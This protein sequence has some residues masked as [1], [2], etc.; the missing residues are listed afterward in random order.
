VLEVHA[1]TKYGNGDTFPLEV[2]PHLVS[3]KPDYARFYATGIDGREENVGALKAR[4]GKS[5]KQFGQ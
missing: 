4:A 1:R 3:S 5:H 2:R